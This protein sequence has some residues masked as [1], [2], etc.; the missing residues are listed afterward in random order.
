VRTLDCPLAVLGLALAALG[1]LVLT[2]LAKRAGPPRTTPITKDNA[3]HQGQPG[4]LDPHQ[5]R[6][7]LY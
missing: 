4:A 5:P 7:L 1:A 3:D 6:L 2:A